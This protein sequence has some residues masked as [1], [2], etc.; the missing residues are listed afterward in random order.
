MQNLFESSDF[1]FDTKRLIIRPYVSSRHS[2]QDTHLVSLQT[3]NI[4]TPA[5]TRFLPQEWQDID[6][7]LKADL[8][9][10]E[11]E[12]ESHVLL[13]QQAGKAE[14]LGFLFLHESAGET[15]GHDIYLG[16]LLKESCWGQGYGTEIIKGLVNHCSRLKGINALIG[17]VP[18]ENIGSVKVL[19]KCGF[20]L[21]NSLEITSETQFY[22]RGLTEAGH[23]N[24]VRY[25]Y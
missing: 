1:R 12:K 21:E 17:G 7:I 22:R 20:K 6:A 24:S 25:E 11:R 13:I 3:V 2:D 8:W 19:E 14:I 16:Y 23:K 15:G 9:L 18:S 5:V 10:K 4:M